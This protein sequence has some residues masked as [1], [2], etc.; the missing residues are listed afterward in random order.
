MDTL[1]LPNELLPPRRILH[2]RHFHDIK[3]PDTRTSDAW[4]I[5]LSY[6]GLVKSL[7]DLRLLE[8]GIKVQVGE[9]RL[10]L[11]HIEFGLKHPVSCQRTQYIFRKGWTTY[12]GHGTNVSE[13]YVAN[14]TN[15]LF[16]FYSF[17]TERSRVKDTCRW[18]SQLKKMKEENKK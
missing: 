3:L 1:N 2:I 10:Q 17:W 5:L 15:I 14:K 9:A 8:M 16:L 7:E 11:V 4:C 13:V 12:P 6:L 18:F